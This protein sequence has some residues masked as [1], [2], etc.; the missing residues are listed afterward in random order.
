M[1]NIS[2]IGNEGLIKSLKSNL[3][4][5]V[6]ITVTSKADIII[7]TVETLGDFNAL[8]KNFEKPALLC[9]NSNDQRIVQYIKNYN[10][11]GIIPFSATKER[12]LNKI[13]TL[14]SVQQTKTVN[15]NE[16]IKT[17]VLAKIDN[18]PPLPVIAQELLKLTRND[19]TSM[20]KIIDKIK[21]DQG[22]SS[23]VL[24]L[25]NSP[26]YAL[27]KEITS[28]DQAAILIGTSTIKNIV[29]SISIEEFYKKNFSLY[30]TTGGKLW[31]HSHHTATISELIARKLKMDTDSAY[32]AGLM[33]DIG[34][35][36][37]VDFLV[38]EVKKPDDEKQQTGL[39][40]S[41]VA[42]FVLEKWNIAKQIINS[43][44]NHHTMTDNNFNIIL[45]YANL[46]EK[47]VESRL[48]LIKD[49]ENRIKIDLTDLVN[50][51]EH[52]RVDHDDV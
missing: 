34:K 37:L 44:L 30:G 28:I 47:D 7:V 39:T 43:V 11:S 46:I 6:N 12:I 38:K 10:F 22:I 49:L 5:S 21:T 41:E 29:L 20:K 19:E 36:V 50:I 15:E 9:L 14:L 52:F 8:P 2:F 13:S 51:L 33:H 1:V 40:H 24:K 26:F 4:S 31:E 17:K 32:L 27:K 23:K 45:Y 35:V 3:S 48:E 16:L 25:V 18:I 42:A